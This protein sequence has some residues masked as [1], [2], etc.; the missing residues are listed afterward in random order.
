MNKN[1]QASRFDILFKDVRIYDGSGKDSFVGDIGVSG[2]RITEVGIINRPS[3]K[4]INAAGLWAA[5]GFMDVH[6]HCDR[7][8]EQPGMKR[9]LVSSG[10][11]ATGQHQYLFQGVTTVVTGNCGFGFTDAGHWLNMVDS[12]ECGTNVFHLA[13]H[14]MLRQELFGADQRSN[15]TQTELDLFKSRLK[16]EMEKGAGGMSLGLEYAPGLL[17]LTAEIISLTKIA[18]RHGGLVSFHMRD[19]SGRKTES[20]EAGVIQAVREV[21]EVARRSE[22]PVQ[23]SH[24][25][26]CSP[27]GDVRPERIIE[28]IEAARSEGLDIT[29]DQYPYDAGQALLNYLLPAVFKTGFSIRNEYKAGE[30]RRLLA[31]AVKEIYSDLSP[32]KILITMFPPRESYEGRTISEISEM[33]QCDPVDIFIDMVSEE[34]APLAAF[35]HQK[36]DIVR[37][38]MPHAFV[39]TAS[40]SRTTPYGATWPH[41]RAYG[42][43]ARKIKKYVMQE[44]VISMANAVR[45]M[46]SLPAEKFGIKERGRIVPGYW[47]DIVII[48]PESISDRATYREPHQYS[49]G[50]V[51]LLVNG[52]LE[53]EN[54][55]LTGNY[56]GRSLRK[57]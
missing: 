49:D 41:P 12:M 48:D 14:G 51:H 11:S 16:D 42:S 10:Q 18:R 56:A 2:D 19:E 36:K 15:L 29:A 34:E 37:A 6:T 32:E 23:I 24:L 33:E 35:F 13:P 43:F 55:N 52:V 25:K 46:T 1:K 39:M 20:G 50:V 53:I 28:E 44:K 47:A 27:F 57:D 9:H 45:S 5:P 26:I 3:E 40:D 4:I 38:L 21:I 31:K 17:A 8:F 7:T 30:G 54:R 22:S